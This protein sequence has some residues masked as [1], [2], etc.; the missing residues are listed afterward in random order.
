MA[1]YFT[2]PL[3]TINSAQQSNSNFSNA[4]H[5]LPNVLNSAQQVDYSSVEP[6]SYGYSDVEDFFTG[7]YGAS[8]QSNRQDRL[9]YK[10]WLRSEESAKRQRDWEEYM[11]SSQVQRQ[12]KD[13]QAAGL[14]P[15]LALQNA[16]FGGAVP[17]GSSGNS[18][19]GQASAGTGS[20]LAGIGQAAAGIAALFKVVASIIK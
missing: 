18:A 2:D 20:G 14:N 17:S 11:S 13:I 3:G 6:S 7:T 4:I 15:W 10:N 16:G 9:D 5:N 12:M 19:S 8:E 1:D